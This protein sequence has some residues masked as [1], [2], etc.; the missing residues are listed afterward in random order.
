MVLRNNAE[1]ERQTRNDSAESS[2]TLFGAKPV[3]FQDEQ[4]PMFPM[5]VLNGRGV[6][7]AETGRFDTNSA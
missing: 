3:S 4:R 6:G 1:Y 2:G 7:S 5:A